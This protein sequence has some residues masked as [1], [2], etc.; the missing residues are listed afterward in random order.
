M[1]RRAGRDGGR[2]GEAVECRAGGGAATPPPGVSIVIPVRDE[3]AALPLAV[4]SALAQDYAGEMEIVVADGSERPETGAAVRARFPG[5]RIVGNPDR[6]IPA[7][8]NRAIAAAAHGIILRCD[9]RCELPPDYVRR[10]VAIL[11]RTGAANVGGCQAPVGDSAFT[12]AVALAMTLPLGA[13]GARYRLGGPAGPVD[14]VFLGVFRRAAL[15]AAGG[16][17]ESLLRNEDY[18]LNWRLRELGATVW[19]DPALAV[20][21]RPRRS[22]GPLARQYFAYG[23]WKRIMLR[24][25]PGSLRWRQLAPPAL[26][27]GLAASGAL[28]AAGLP[29][30]GAVL[31]AAW[32]LALLCCAAGAALS[33]PGAAAL[34]LPVVLATMHLAWG[35]GF[36][37]ASLAPRTRAR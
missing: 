2:R 20:R 14:T 31:P 21:Y 1:R 34:L 36:W 9:A 23:W 26:A 4:A 13:G 35:A 5:V 11:E 22:L 6:H 19:F 24:R 37:A 27:L 28:A 17:D 29:L 8:L 3:A 12:R 25:H 7:G 33:R 18:A 16:F 10:A 32:A 15:E 30:A